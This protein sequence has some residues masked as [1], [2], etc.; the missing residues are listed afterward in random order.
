MSSVT[1]GSDGSGSVPETARVR[2]GGSGPSPSLA[3]VEA[4]AELVGVAPADLREEGVVLYD[5]VDPD[6]LNALVTDRSDADVDVSLIV[7]GYEVRVGP[8][9]AVARRSGN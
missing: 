9:S 4:I 5:Y 3:V 2:H 6:A 7:A 8:D 1:A